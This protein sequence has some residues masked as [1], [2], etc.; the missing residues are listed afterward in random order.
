LQ[1]LL[2]YV[3]QQ[4]CVHL[5]ELLLTDKRV[6][7]SAND[8]SAIY[9]AVEYQNVN[10]VKLLLDDDRIVVSELLMPSNPYI[11]SLMLLRRS[12]RNDAAVK[13]AKFVENVVVEIE[14]IE[15]Q[16]KALLDDHL[17]SDLSNLCLGYVPDLFLRPEIDVT[18]LPTMDSIFPRFTFGC[19]SSL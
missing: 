13:G 14:K 18:S 16:R 17:V 11:A 3:I 10:V 8:Q 5:L 19:L 2:R 9:A 1:S 15:S 7:P 4:G 6:D 12:C